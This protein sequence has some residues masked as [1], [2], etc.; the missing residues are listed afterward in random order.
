MTK[1]SSASERFPDGP[2]SVCHPGRHWTHAVLHWSDP[3]GDG[4]S[5]GSRRKVCED[6]VRVSWPI[7]FVYKC[8]YYNICCLHQ[9]WNTLIR[10]SST[11]RHIKAKLYK[12]P[13]VLALIDDPSLINGCA[14]MLQG[15]L[16]D[17][18]PTTSGPSTLIMA[19]W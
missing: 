9:L 11:L 14:Q 16:W 2:G 13:A 12:T 1:A 6:P 18:V 5:Q 17:L 8:L 3:A 4:E 10:S 7:V 15:M 19:S